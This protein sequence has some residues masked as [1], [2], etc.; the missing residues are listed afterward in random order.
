MITGGI[1]IS[2]NLHI[3]I[4]IYSYAVLT[5][6]QYMISEG[7]VVPWPLYIFC[8][9]VRWMNLAKATCY[10]IY[11]WLI[12]VVYPI[13]SPGF[14]NPHY[15]WV[16]PLTTA[17]L[18]QFMPL[19]QPAESSLHRCAFWGQTKSLSH[20]EVG[21]QPGLLATEHVG[22]GQVISMLPMISIPKCNLWCWWPICQHE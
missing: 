11:Y 5:I 7:P 12:L 13:T 14:L 18:G 4:A 20:E 21:L 1:P 22:M 16:K 10:P 3:Y 9:F 15:Q 2:G 6:E 8:F 19:T 17:I